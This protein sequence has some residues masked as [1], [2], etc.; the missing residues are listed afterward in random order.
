MLFL[1]Y[2]AGSFFG[3]DSIDLPAWDPTVRYF[4]KKK[5]KVYAKASSEYILRWSLDTALLIIK[6]V[7]TWYIAL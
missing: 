1:N 3:N 6:I 7:T 2:K 5:K 4:Y